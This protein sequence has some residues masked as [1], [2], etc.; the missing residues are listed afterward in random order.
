[1]ELHASG[2]GHGDGEL[3]EVSW[4]AATAHEIV[5]DIARDIELGRMSRAQ[6]LDLIDRVQQRA[7][8]ELM[9]RR[10][11]TPLRGDRDG[12]CPEASPGRKVPDR[13][14]A[15]PRRRVSDSMRA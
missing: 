10:P 7:A 12:A 3:T 11:L 1:M 13:P 9:E 2:S 15:H 8:P 14:S 4:S 5:A 6:G